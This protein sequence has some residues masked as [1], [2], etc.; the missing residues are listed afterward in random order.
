MRIHR[1]GYSTLMLVGGVMT[2]ITLLAAWWRRAALWLLL[3]L[4]LGVIGFFAQFFRSP[5]RQITAVP[6]GI[7]APADG[8]IVALEA[9]HEGEC[10]HEQRLKLSIYMSAL[11]VHLNRV[12]ADGTVIYR[13][14]H[15]G[16]YL[17]AFHPKASEL[18]E[19]NT[20]VLECAGGQR[21]LLRQIAGLL[22]R[23]IRCYVAAG[24]AVSAGDELG[25]IKFGSRFD[26]FLPLDAQLQ[27]QIGQ[28]V[29]GGETLLALLVNAG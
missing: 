11:N 10:F 21:V 28:K 24:Q 3:P 16:R 17:L 7:L 19:R 27:V 6:N 15:P 2:G 25:F 5:R 14:Y 12:P 9:V 26:V 8:T 29:R 4:S 1:E 20:V 23:R 18:N 22:A 13:R